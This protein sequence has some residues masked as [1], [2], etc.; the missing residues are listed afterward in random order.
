MI[1]HPSFF[2]I[3]CFLS[4]CIP[5]STQPYIYILVVCEFERTPTKL[6]GNPGRCLRDTQ[7]AS[8]ALRLFWVVQSLF[9]N[10]VYL[11]L[12]LF[13]PLLPLF[14][15][16]ALV[17]ITTC[18]TEVQEGEF[19]LDS[20]CCCCCD[21][22]LQTKELKEERVHFSSQFQETVHH[23]S[24]WEGLEATGHITSQG[25]EQCC[26][27]LLGS[28]LHTMQEPSLT[29]TLPSGSFPLSSHSQDNPP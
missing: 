18:C 9:L 28:S 10:S 5:L 14:S 6:K 3:F 29:A 11:M 16:A 12:K 26:L 25:T 19:V 24:Q 13:F 7:G 15:A 22:M 23:E 20:F 2:V 1:S 21:Q 17:A 27:L 8:R 4:Q